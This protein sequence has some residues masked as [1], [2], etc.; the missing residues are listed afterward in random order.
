MND[1]QNSADIET[2]ARIAARLAGRDPDRH[3]TIKVAD[4]FV[5]DDLTWRYPDF[6]LRAQAAYD[7]LIR[8]SLTIRSGEL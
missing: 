3:L 7:V 8:G 4:V 5:F 1:A 2:L 6:L